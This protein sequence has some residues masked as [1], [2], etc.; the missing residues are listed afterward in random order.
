MRHTHFDHVV[1]GA[2]EP[3][4]PDE[5]RTLADDILRRIYRGDLA[6]A[7]ERAAA[8]CRVI[9]A[10]RAETRARRRRPRPGR[11]RTETEQAASLLTTAEE[12]DAAAAAWRRDALY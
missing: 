3:P 12:L 7:L 5:L 1:A 6:V 11:A 10:G 8:F 2:A 9:S 4:G